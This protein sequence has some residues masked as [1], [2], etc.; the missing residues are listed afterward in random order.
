[1]KNRKS[2][3]VYAFVFA[4]GGSK[5][6]IGKNLR[7]VAGKPLLAHSIDTA[8]KC[9]SIKEIFVSTDDKQIAKV[10]EDL[11][12]QVIE[13]P[14]ELATDEAPE[15]LAWQ[16]AVHWLEKKGH[17]FDVFLSLPTTSPL[18]NTQDVENCLNALTENTDFVVTITKSNRS[19]WFN[20]V[21]K[22]GELLYLLCSEKAYT[23]RQDTPTSYDMT[24][25]AYVSRPSCIK[26]SNSIFEC[27]VKGV[28]IP[29]DR[30][31]DI[32]TE[33]DLEIAEALMNKR[34]SE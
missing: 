28:L 24:T 23:R 12:A 14:A 16:H 1:M 4:R 8:R 5:G 9:K 3:I 30:A 10:A 26:L 29:Q 31:L 7:T 21:K 32:D 11:G 17:N 34:A 13:R 6:V 18:R 19:P 20:M 2:E 25:V 33:C 15:W 27:R 22:K